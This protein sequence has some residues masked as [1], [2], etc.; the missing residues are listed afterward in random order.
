[1]TAFS[2]FFLRHGQK[3][4]YFPTFTF[5]S[6][7]FPI[8]GGK[9]MNPLRD[10]IMASFMN[11]GQCFWETFP[12]CSL[13]EEHLRPRTYGCDLMAVLY[14]S[15]VNLIILYLFGSCKV[16]CIKYLWEYSAKNGISLFCR[17][18]LWGN[19][20]LKASGVPCLPSHVMRTCRGWWS[21]SDIRCGKVVG[22]ICVS[23]GVIHK[24]GL[25]QWGLSAGSE[26]VLVRNSRNNWEWV[27]Q[28]LWD[29]S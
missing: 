10:S 27:A 11:S 17:A 4:V 14:Q 1:M 7:S 12:I 26:W 24:A 2:A 15:W 8:C 16:F 23:W 6:S 25:V 28:T 5:L 20:Q 3:L 21:Q 18:Q 9:V 22:S 19:R 29:V 13:G